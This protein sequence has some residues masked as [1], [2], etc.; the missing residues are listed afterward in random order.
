MEELSEELAGAVSAA[1]VGIPPAPERGLQAWLPG[2]WV[3]RHYQRAYLC[4]DLT[5]GIVLGAVLVPAG[6]GY[7]EASGL[8]AVTRGFCGWGSSRTC[9][10]SRC[11]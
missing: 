4:Y 3:L 8:P 10:P 5:A 6:M 1:G 2:L 7:A 9:S 11:V